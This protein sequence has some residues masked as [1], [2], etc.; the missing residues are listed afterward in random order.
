MAMDETRRAVVSRAVE[1]VRYVT[2]CRACRREVFVQAVRTASGR[3]SVRFR[4]P[5]HGVVRDTAVVQGWLGGE[6]SP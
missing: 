1:P 3:V 5:R 2:L 6:G 4:C